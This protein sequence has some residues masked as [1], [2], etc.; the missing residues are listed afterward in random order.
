[1]ANRWVFC[2]DDASLRLPSP[3]N[4]APSQQVDYQS[5]MNMNSNNAIQVMSAADA[6]AAS[7]GILKLLRDTDTELQNLKAQVATLQQQ[8]AALTPHP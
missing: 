2:F 8:V 7:D 3:K 4:Y 1:M 5:Q 6:Q